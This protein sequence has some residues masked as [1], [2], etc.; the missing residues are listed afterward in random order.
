VRIVTFATGG[1][2]R[3]RAEALAASARQHGETV[4]IVTLPDRGSWWANVAQKPG[5][6]LRQRLAGGGP[7]LYLDSDC[8]IHAPLGA[9]GQ[10]L[11]GFDLV[12]RKRPP[13]VKD[14]YNAGVLLMADN[15]GVLRFLEIWRDLSVCYA[16]RSPTA[17]QQYM[18][19]AVLRSGVAVRDLHARYNAFPNDA[20]LDTVVSHSKTSREDPALS[21]WRAARHLE[22]QLCDR[23]FAWIKTEARPAVRLMGVAGE[24]IPADDHAA[25]VQTVGWLC[26]APHVTA[27]WM[28]SVPSAVLGDSSFTPRRVVPTDGD[29][30]N[31]ADYLRST[32]CRLKPKPS[33][34]NPPP[35]LHLYYVDRDMA[36]DFKR[37]EL[38]FSLWGAA[39]NAAKL[40]KCK[41]IVA[42]CAPGLRALVQAAAAACHLELVLE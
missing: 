2:Y 34:E 22:R 17:D 18:E 23:T 29:A 14:R 3:Q 31:A 19:E 36:L 32:Q 16:H 30:G 24:P 26:R 8:L 5:E 25:E 12:A 1:V 6:L 27:A 38:T 37:R 10:D 15:P 33:A 28:P 13:E 21:G 35:F 11:E 9:L 7:L 42:H 4:E 41:R 39:V 40:R 20:A